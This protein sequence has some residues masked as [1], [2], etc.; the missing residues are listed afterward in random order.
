MIFALETV[1]CHLLSFDVYFLRVL[2]F[3]YG[4]EVMRS[5]SEFVCLSGIG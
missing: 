5:D 2:L 1:Y 3:G 4:I